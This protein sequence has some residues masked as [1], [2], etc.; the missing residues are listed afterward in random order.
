MLQQRERGL[1][2]R[3]I[4]CVHATGV[5]VPSPPSSFVRFDSPPLSTLSII[6]ISTSF[7][8]NIRYQIP[9]TLFKERTKKNHFR[10]PSPSPQIQIQPKPNQPSSRVTTTPY[11][12][13]YPHTQVYRVTKTT[14]D[15]QTV[16]EEFV[17]RLNIHVYWAIWA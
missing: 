9:P 11:S 1:R 10:P 14:K 13:P 4:A 2:N 17:I 7:F 6:L 15:R 12:S 5:L 8:Y 3:E 16:R